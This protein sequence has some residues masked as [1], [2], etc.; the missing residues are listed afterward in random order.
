MLKTARMGAIGMTST[1]NNPNLEEWQQ[2]SA[3][4]TSGAS[5]SASFAVK[6]GVSPARVDA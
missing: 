1:N 5:L 3:F 2:L 4:L 6:H